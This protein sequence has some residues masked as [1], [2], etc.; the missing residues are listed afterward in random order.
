[1]HM[2]DTWQPVRFEIS[3]SSMIQVVK[4]REVKNV[5]NLVPEYH[6]ITLCPYHQLGNAQIK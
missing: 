3:G 4:F 6:I 2:R 1:M 5:I